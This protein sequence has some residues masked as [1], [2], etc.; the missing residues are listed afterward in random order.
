MVE[1]GRTRR[2]R[3]ARRLI[4]EVGEVLIVDEDL[5]VG[6]REGYTRRG[7]KNRDI[8]TISVLPRIFFKISVTNA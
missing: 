4:V 3:P 1:F 2:L 6:D 7:V 5:A 8:V